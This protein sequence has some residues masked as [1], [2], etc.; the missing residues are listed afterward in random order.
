[1]SPGG[2]PAFAWNRYLK[3]VDQLTVV[4]R[5]SLDS[6]KAGLV[7]S[8]TQ[9][10]TFDLLYNV[11]GGLDYYKHRKSIEAKLREHIEKVDFVVIRVPSTIGY[12]AYKICKQMNVPF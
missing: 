11:R 3:N 6:R 8:S 4:S 7:L 5:G 10:V 2:L 1:F 9:C 12:F